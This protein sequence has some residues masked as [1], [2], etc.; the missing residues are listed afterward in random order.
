MLID[1]IRF[2]RIPVY[3]SSRARQTDEEGLIIDTAEGTKHV[4]AGTVVLSVGYRAD[5]KLAEELLRAGKEVY[6]AGEA[7]DGSGNIL[8]S[9]WDA[10]EI[11]SG[12]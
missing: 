7:K 8:Q 1:L 12:L 3:E 2:F 10:Y 6:V 9:V 11:A 5:Q 4:P